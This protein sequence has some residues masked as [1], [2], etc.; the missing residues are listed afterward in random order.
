MNLLRSA[1]LRA[2]QNSWLRE[3]GT[4]YKF[5]RRT[6]ARF[7]PGETA[8]EALAAAKELTQGGLGTILS[9]LGEGVTDRAEA[10]GVTQH[11]LGVLER[12]REMGLPSELSVKLT[13]LGLDIDFDFCLKNFA[14]VAERVPAE[15]T[16][17]IDMEQSPYVDVTL[18][19]C[20][21]AR[22]RHPNVGV[23]VQAYLFRTERDVEFL[24]AAGAPVRLVK[25][26]Y[27][28]PP[29]IAFAE[30]ADADENYF[31]LAQILLGAEARRAGVRAALG[32]HDRKLIHRVAEWAAGQGI[33]KS[34]IEFQMLYGIQGAEQLRLA[35]EGYR[36]GVFICY[37]SYWFP[38]FMRRLAE[39]PANV[40]FL[41]KN[42]FSRS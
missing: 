31:Q 11:Y 26:A 16:L 24:I 22:R 29:E 13:Q 34:E 41:A 1:I 23:C 19:F 33:A 36:S 6:V 4:R 37:G 5:M 17:W 21:Q 20:R 38:W 8:E 18:D 30:K 10:E 27:S 32:T 40:A 2:S 25:G 35:R 12:I 28:E 3:S 42:L 15:R 9:H 39:R 7:M 14:K